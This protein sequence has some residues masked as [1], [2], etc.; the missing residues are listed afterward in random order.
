MR[1]EEMAR[2]LG[3]E[4]LIDAAEFTRLT[5]TPEGANQFNN[6]FLAASGKPADKGLE[7]FLFPDTYEVK[8]SGS[9]NLTP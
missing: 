7:G 4:G 9:D 1:A 2:K 5:T 3:D 6:D 8:Q